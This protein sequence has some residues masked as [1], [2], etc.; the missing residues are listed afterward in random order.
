MED[1]NHNIQYYCHECKRQVDATRPETSGDSEF[2]CSIC[3]GE[4]IEQIDANEQQHSD[5][6]SSP[7][8]R[9]SVQVGR[10]IPQG[11]PS[12]GTS[13]FVFQYP[14]ALQSQQSIN[15]QNGEQVEAVGDLT[16]NLLGFLGHLVPSDTRR[17]AAS[18]DNIEQDMRNESIPRLNEETSRPSYRNHQ[19][20]SREYANIIDLVHDLFSH[21]ERFI[22][23]Q[24]GQDNQASSL[25]IPGFGSVMQF[26]E[27]SGDYVF[28]D[29]AFD[30]IISQLLEQEA[31][32]H[33]PSPASEETIQ[34]LVV[35]TVN[36]K[37]IQESR[38]CP[39]CKE[40]FQ[41]DEQVTEI[42]CNHIFHKECIISWLKRN[43]TC[44]VCRYKLQD[45]NNQ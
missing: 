31:L 1:N 6:R 42:P 30:N 40:S 27:V 36:Q 8:I 21:P 34:R 10:I 2:I 5:T 24:T 33:A 16:R 45:S 29:N 7:N 44:P 23:Q 37:D 3:H 17:R 9:L 41:L 12:I 18:N 19:E 38:E 43:G 4:F 26:P 20:A 11:P 14:P 28:G 32:R 39:V 22:V 15:T 35:R 13:R 25:W